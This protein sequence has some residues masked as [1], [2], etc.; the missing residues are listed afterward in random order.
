MVMHLKV[1]Y[2]LIG[3]FW[4]NSIPVNAQ[5]HRV[6]DSLT[7]IYLA[8]TLTGDAKLELL[9]DLAFNE[10]ND[11]T[12]A[13]K[14]AEEL[15][16]LATIH[17]NSS[18]LSQGYF[19]KGTAHRQL[20]ELERALK[21]YIKCAEISK[22]EEHKS[23]EGSAYGA[24]ADI[25]AVSENYS[26]AMLYYHKAIKVLR[27]DTDTIALAATLSNAG[28]ALLN[29]KVYDSAL[30]YFKEA[31]QLF[32]E[33]KYDLGKAYTLGNIGMVYANLGQNDI[34]EKNIDEAIR[35]LEA[36]EDFYPISV[37]LLSM[38]DI[39]IEKGDSSSAINY[40]QRSLSLAKKYRLKDQISDANLKLSG[41][42]EKIGNTTASLKHYKDHVTYRDSVN[43]IKA[44]QS[45]ANM[46]TD[47]EVSQKQ[48]EVDLLNQ[49]K[50]NQ[51]IILGF[52]VVGLFTLFWYYRTIS[53]EKKRSEKLLLNILPTEIAQELKK[54]GQVEAVKCEAVTVLFTDFV[55]F[56]KIA[57]HTEPE[58]LV[59]SIDYYFKK[60]DEIT[61]NF[62]LEKIKT[63]G[64]SYMCASGL[65]TSNPRHAQNAIKA[66][67]AM[68]SFV[69]ETGKTGKDISRFE[70]RVGLHSGP[71]VAGIVGIK[72]WQY[73]IW[74]DTVNIA[75]R[76]ESNSKPGRINLSE[77]TY[78]EIKEEYPCEFRGEIKVKN[79]GAFKMYFLQTQNE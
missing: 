19:Q 29:N 62:G 67:I 31:E 37:Y 61:S 27:K 53:K 12:L 49:Q 34:G 33:V 5:D 68:T 7:A 40:A 14:Y 15:I 23:F 22:K 58:Q 63:V 21:A 18:Y 25:Y 73:D 59:K 75:S 76:M 74:G 8:D 41:L 4:L 11:F 54:N 60:F 52:T 39:E 50:R 45:M 77:T 42:Y 65:P 79:R 16:A 72:K 36:Y 78:S 13:N 35:I 32:E 20:G 55:E 28:D 10:I 17:G 48:V 24:I 9:A 3:F 44:V 71:V 6:A 38:A 47:F 56:S 26:N 30:T 51:R 57:E 69:A 43:N 46:R 70:I 66:A 1:Y 64:D 2:F